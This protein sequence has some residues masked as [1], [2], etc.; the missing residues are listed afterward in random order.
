MRASD[1]A[2]FDAIPF[3]QA[4]R[5]HGSAVHQRRVRCVAMMLEGRAVCAI[6]DYGLPSRNPGVPEQDATTRLGRL[7]A[8]PEDGLLA[9]KREALAGIGSAEHE[10]LEDRARTAVAR[11]VITAIVVAAAASIL[12]RSVLSGL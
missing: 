5:P 10:Q 8:A 11:C 4:R 1:A 12:V 9:R 6:A 3:L 2:E 7:E